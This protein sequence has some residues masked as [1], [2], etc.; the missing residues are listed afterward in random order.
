MEQRTGMFLVL[1][2]I[3]ARQAMLSS[4]HVTARDLHMILRDGR[5]MAILHA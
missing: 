1:L 2:N 5:H 3:Q 4:I